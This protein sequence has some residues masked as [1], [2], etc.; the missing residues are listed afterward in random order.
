MKKS[1]IIAVFMSIFGLIIGTVGF[2]SYIKGGL[3]GFIYLVITIIDIVPRINTYNVALQ[4]KKEGYQFMNNFL[5]TLSVHRNIVHTYEI[6]QKQFSSDLMH[7]TN[8]LE[9]ML[10]NEKLGQLSA[11]FQIKIYILFIDFLTIYEQE[12]GEVL[13]MAELLLTNI[14][15]EAAELTKYDLLYGRKMIEFILLWLMTFA[16]LV[17]T[18]FSLGTMYFTMLTNALF[19]IILGGFFL[20]FIIATS[21]LFRLMFKSKDWGNRYESVGTKIKKSWFQRKKN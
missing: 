2:S 7:W 5:I 4:R 3:V 15:R 13:Q 9:G 10:V 14:R 19:Q 12:G 1:W 16:I 8:D 11:Y 21:I 18:R 20:V 17:T 6:T